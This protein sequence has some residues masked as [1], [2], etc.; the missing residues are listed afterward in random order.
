M[1]FLIK[2]NVKRCKKHVT[3]IV[4]FTIVSMLEHNAKCYN[5]KMAFS[6]WILAKCIQ[7]TYLYHNVQ[8]MA[9]YKVAMANV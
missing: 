4:M 5:K 8:G 9:L 1:L 2:D 7:E 3:L 6:F